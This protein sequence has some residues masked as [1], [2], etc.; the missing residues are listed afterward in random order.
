MMQL[1]RL[2]GIAAAAVLPLMI[3]G[4]IPARAQ[5]MPPIKPMRLDYKVTTLRN[6]L[7]VVTLEDHR[8]PVVTLQ[9]WYRV[10]SKD[11]AKGKSGF[12]HLFEHLMF[13]GSRNIGPEEH[14]K[15][16]EQIGGEVNANTWFDR[17]MY[18]ETFAANALDRMLFLEAERLSSLRVDEANLASERDVVKEEYRTRVANQPY[19]KLL[20]DVQR[21]IFP[22]A[23]PYAHTTIGSLADLDGATLSEVK[24]FHEEYY[25]PDNA[26]MV[27]VGD[28]KTDAALTKITQYFGGIPKSRDGKFT[29]YPAPADTQKKENRQTYYDRLAPLPA[30]GMAF[31]LPLPTHRDT[32]VF[33][34]IGKILSDGQS[35]RLYRSLVRDQ[36]IAVEASGDSLDLKLGGMFFF[37]GIA[38]MGKQPGLLEKALVAEVEKLRAAPVT[39]QEL[40]KAKNQALTEEVFGTLS[41]EAK[42]TALGEAD[43][44]YGNPEEANR[45]LQK[46][47]A[48]TAA[49][50]QRV[51]RT[52][53]A[54]ARRNV[55]YVL[56][57]PQNKQGSGPQKTAV[58]K[59]AK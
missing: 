38:N 52:Y 3:A 41:T 14:G 51:A 44:L 30:V 15:Y 47:N 1:R 32:P 25:K 35:S 18:Y 11:E 16:V 27:L 5:E 9:I 20:E 53:F 23:H 54:P 39:A 26:T 33:T 49:D 43:L 8:A 55:F 21:L 24:A 6:G 42:A 19:G 17:T 34:I 46:L 31:R 7:K 37:F 28:F 12:A 40:A 29:R 2:G 57:D 36:Q 45:S 58:P 56:P 22:A 4:Y 13:K 48:V 50:V 10:G 59:A